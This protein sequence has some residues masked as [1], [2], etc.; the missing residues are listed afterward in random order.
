MQ[1]TLVRAS[2]HTHLLPLAQ[3]SSTTR[4]LCAKTDSCTLKAAGVPKSCTSCHCPCGQASGEVID[5]HEQLLLGGRVHIVS[6][7]LLNKSREPT[8]A[9]LPSSQA[10]RLPMQHKRKGHRVLFDRQLAMSP[11]HPTGRA[12]G[13]I[14]SSLATDPKALLPNK[15]T[16]SPRPSATCPCHH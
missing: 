12:P 10:P 8:P 7:L 2:S 15:S 16:A 5:T 14:L 4:L 6:P 13:Q 1:S 3:Q 9:N 11:A